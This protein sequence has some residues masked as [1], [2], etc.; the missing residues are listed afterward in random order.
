MVDVDEL[1]QQE[2]EN[3]ESQDNTVIDEI[4]ELE[5]L[6][7]GGA[8]AKIPIIVEYPKE[9]GT[10]EELGLKLKPLTDV[11]VNNAL[12]SFKKNK[13]TSI[14]IEYLKRGLYTKDDKPFP[15][16]LIK[17][18]HTGVIA[19]LHDKLCEISGIHIDEQEQKR[20]MNDLMG[21]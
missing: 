8:K 9:D 15:A 5:H 13:N 10:T 6:I 1:R 14:R 20:V 16:N 19:E 7:L 4:S 11:E 2:L 12:K 3:I 18:M 21:F 17:A